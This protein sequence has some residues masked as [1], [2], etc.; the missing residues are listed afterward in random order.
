MRGFKDVR[1][2]VRISEGEHLYELSDTVQL[3]TGVR[4]RFDPPDHAHELRRSSFLPT[5][6]FSLA[7]AMLAGGINPT[8]RQ[9]RDVRACRLKGWVGSLASECFV[10]EHTP[11]LSW[12]T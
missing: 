5:L 11:P 4:D 9:E 6:R 7:E 1:K 12:R 8:G 2:A 3:S 10:L